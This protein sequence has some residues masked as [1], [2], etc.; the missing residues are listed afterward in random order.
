MEKSHEVAQGAQAGDERDLFNHWMHDLVHASEVDGRVRKI[1]RMDTMT[2][3]E[4]E[5]AWDAWEARAALATQPAVRGAK[6]D[7]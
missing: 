3:Q 2:A 1:M 4:E 7:Q 5:R 6:H